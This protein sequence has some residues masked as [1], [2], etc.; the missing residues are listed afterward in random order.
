MGSRA[1][2]WAQNRKHG[3]EITNMGTRAQ[4]WA[5]K[6]KYGLGITN[7]GSRSQTWAQN[8]KH[9]LEITNMGSRAQTW[10]RNHKHGPERHKHGRKIVNMA[11]ER[12][13]GREN[14]NMLP[15]SPQAANHDE[16]STVLPKDIPLFISPIDIRIISQ[17]KNR[18]DFSALMLYHN[19][20]LKLNERDRNGEGKRK[21][22]GL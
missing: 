7:M 9:G 4:T 11:R 19:K 3:L 5:Q 20:V 13:H 21:W 2:T 14:P 12:K 17:I 15:N 22:N 10:A 18:V 1:Q 16:P 8:R 6:R